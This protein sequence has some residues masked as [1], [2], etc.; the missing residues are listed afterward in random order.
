MYARN[1]R[2]VK[3]FKLFQS[4]KSGALMQIFATER[5]RLFDYVMRMTAHVQ[6]ASETVT[7]ALD[8]L[9]PVADSAES[10]DELM[11][12]MFKTARNFAIDSWNVETSKLENNAYDG[13]TSGGKDLQVLISVEHAVRSLSPHQ[14][15]VLLLVERFWFAPEEVAEITGMSP[16]DVEVALSQA[17]SIVEQVVSDI[18]GKLHEMMG[19]L[20]G[21]IEPESDSLATQNLSLIMNDFKKT[22]RHGGGRSK[23]FWIG[24]IAV[25][26]GLAY[27][28]FTY[29]EQIKD[30][31][32]SFQDVKR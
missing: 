5:P 31:L 11:V 25:F 2:L 28:G 20:L 21:Y 9:E 3:A 27:G 29:Q 22:D 4:G 13:I 19:R 30:L 6:K 17:Q 1:D 18:H 12:I 7:E 14:R 10:L 16:S 8:S 15:E 26:A 23:W 32:R 24:L